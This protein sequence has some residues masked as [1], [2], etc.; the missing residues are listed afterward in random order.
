M[1]GALANLRDGFQPKA[2][3]PE[4]TLDLNL[5]LALAMLLGYEWRRHDAARPHRAPAHRL[6]TR[7]SLP[8]TAPCHN[9]WPAWTERTLGGG[10]P[11][12]IAVST[13]ADPLD[14]AFDAYAR[15]HHAERI[16][17]LHVPGVLDADG[18]RGLARHVAARCGACT[19][20]ASS[21]ICSSPARSRSRHSS[22]RPRT[23]TAPSWCR[24][25][26]ARTTSRRSP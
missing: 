8:A 3:F 2:D 12:V 23:A 19:A 6:G 4:I 5:P 9:S 14:A 18:I 15:E 17:G 11:T 16:L 21:D 13:T 24:Y 25:G 20:T 22:A 7:S 26:R 1:R 10:G